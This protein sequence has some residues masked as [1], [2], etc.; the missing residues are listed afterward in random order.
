MRQPSVAAGSPGRAGA[1]A[2]SRTNRSRAATIARRLLGA[3]RGVDQVSRGGPGRDEGEAFA[4]GE[5]EPLTAGTRWRVACRSPS[6]A[7]RGMFPCFRLGPGSRLLCERVQGL[8]SRGRV[9]WG[10]MTSSM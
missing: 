1:G 10:T 5:P 9:S 7:H 3:G 6:G 8:I 2:V 4:T